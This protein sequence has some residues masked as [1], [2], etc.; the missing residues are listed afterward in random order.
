VQQLLCAALLKIARADVSADGKSVHRRLECEVGQLFQQWAAYSGVYSGVYSGASGAGAQVEPEEIVLRALKTEQLS[1][2]INALFCTYMWTRVE[3]SFEAA[4]LEH[5]HGG[6][7]CPLLMAPNETSH[8]LYRFTNVLEVLT[9]TLESL[10]CRVQFTPKGLNSLL[11]EHF[12]MLS[13]L[14]MHT[15]THTHPQN[16]MQTHASS[17]SASSTSASSASASSASS[18][19]ASSASAA[20]AASASASRLAD[21]G[22]QGGQGGAVLKMLTGWWVCRAKDVA[23]E[24]EDMK[25]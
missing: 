14:S 2:Q 1:S 11:R 22:G 13:M 16:Y 8:K 3:S 12:S 15:H 19:S 25:V 17:A 6:A 24:C 7:S 23:A 4:F 5:T 9:E 18:T 10:L 20:S 21:Q